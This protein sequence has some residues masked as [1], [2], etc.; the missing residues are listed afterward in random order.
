MKVPDDIWMQAD[1]C[2][3]GSLCKKMR[4]RPSTWQNFDRSQSL[5]LSQSENRPAVTH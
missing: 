5:I 3:V 4:D 1:F 2:G